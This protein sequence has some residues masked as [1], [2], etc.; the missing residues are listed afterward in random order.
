MRWLAL[1]PL[2]LTIPLL[3]LGFT[4]LISSGAYWLNSRHLRENVEREKLVA[5]PV[6]MTRLQMSVEEHLN[7]GEFGR[8]QKE[9]SGLLLDNNVDW[10]IL[11]EQERIIVAATSLALS[12][13]SIEEAS[14]SEEERARILALFREVTGNNR[15]IT[16]LSEDRQAIFSA[17]PVSF[18][19]EAGLLRPVR[20]GMLVMRYSLAA[21]KA[22]A[23]LAAGENVGWFSA[24]FVLLSLLLWLYFHFFLTRRVEKIVA[25]ARDFAGGKR[26]VRIDSEGRDEVA[27]VGRALDGMIAARLAAES[28]ARES[29]NFLALVADGLPVFIAY[30]DKEERYRFVN[31]EYQRWYGLS[32]QEIIG[33]HAR[34]LLGASEYERLRGY[35]RRAL[36]G[37]AVDFEDTLML[38]GQARTMQVNYIPHRVEGEGVAG[39][40]LLRQDITE[41]RRD[42]EQLW[43]AKEQWERTFAAIDDLVTI[44]DQD[45]RVLRA[46]EAACLFFGLPHD[47][48]VGNRCHEL[49]LGSDS[50]CPGCPFTSQ[51]GSGAPQQAEI[52]VPRARKNFLVSVAPLSA[53]SEG[54]VLQIVHTAKDLTAFKDLESRLRQAQKMEAVGT[55]AGGIARDFNNILTPILGYAELLAEKLPTDREEHGQVREI[56]KAATRARE[57]VGQILAF[58]RQSELRKQPVSLHLLVKEALRLLR[59]SIPT[60]IEIQQDL[61]DCGMVLADPTQIHQIVMNLCANAYHAMREKGGILGVSLDLVALGQDDYLDNLAIVPGRYLKLT[62]RDTGMGME[63]AL[64]ERIFEPYFTTKKKGEGTGMGLAVVHGIVQGHQGHITVYS[65]P[66]QGTEFHVYLP[67][68]EGDAAGGLE[69]ESEHGTVGLPQAGRIL[70]VDDEEVIVQLLCKILTGMGYE[71]LACTSSTAALE[72]FRQ[73]T[74]KIDLVLTDMSMPVLTGAELVRKVKEIR[75]DM[76]VILCT[77]F[78]EVIDE[79]KAKKLGVDAFLLKPIIRNKLAE[80]LR[81][82][83][84]A[85]NEP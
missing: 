9:I 2:R 26:E 36:A 23:S 44:Q 10:A 16:R 79:E 74:G 12:G 33:R 47:Q 32:P 82:A 78:S 71:V 58:S 50:P 37:E 40:Y 63:K 25:A 30:V 85:K 52:V 22:E 43:Q 8:V 21:P 62:V 56:L 68:F 61:A 70:V 5:L 45:F 29:E 7:D 41:S 57:L 31:R 72:L 3:L 17:V 20:Y 34:E 76:P 83:L 35:I 51:A 55:L 65:E 54:G 46:N 80:S 39:F 49:F 66:G 64:L 67:R 13:L 15:G 27:E 14:F 84:A 6:L 42:R 75:P 18:G 24:F 53:D 19:V 28:R 77:G 60:S 1:Y 73:E 11:V 48:V 38:A 4:L 81:L 69:T 59:S